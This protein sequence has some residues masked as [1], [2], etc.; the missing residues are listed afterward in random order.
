MVKTKQFLI[1]EVRYFVSDLGNLD[2]IFFK[3]HNDKP[4]CSICK[5]LFRVGDS[6]TLICN[7]FKIFPNIGV[8]TECFE[9]EET[10]KYILKDYEDFKC[11]KEKYKHWL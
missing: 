6:F 9:D 7:N 2:D 10:I 11:F 8:H 3:I 4:S 5:A 1:D